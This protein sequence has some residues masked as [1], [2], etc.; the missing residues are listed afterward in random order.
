MPSISWGDLKLAA[1]GLWSSGNAFSVV[2]NHL[3]LSGSS[4]DKYFLVDAGRMLPA[5]MHSANCK[6]WWRRNNDL[7]EIME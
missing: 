3:S 5:P 4:M 2:M 7:R 1:I 6:V